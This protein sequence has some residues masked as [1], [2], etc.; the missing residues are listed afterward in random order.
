M[1]KPQCAIC[2]CYVTSGHCWI[3][4][5]CRE[6]FSLGTKWS[7]LPEWV[8]FLVHEEQGRRRVRPIVEVDFSDLCYCDRAKV[9][10]AIGDTDS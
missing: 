3:C 5:H 1:N 4:R 6:E 7:E 10:A 8:R 2:Q 9:E